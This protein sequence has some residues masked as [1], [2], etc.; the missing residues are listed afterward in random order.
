MGDE[1]ALHAN[2]VAQITENPLRPS[3]PVSESPH[4]HLFKA[5][6]EQGEALFEPATF[7][8]TPYYRNAAQ[9]LGFNGAYFQAWRENEIAA[10]ARNFVHLLDNPE[11]FVGGIGHSLPGEPIRAREIRY[12]DCYC[13]IDGH[14]RLGI[15]SARGERTAAVQVLRPAMVTPIQSKLLDAMWT[16]ASHQLYQPVDV[17]EV[18]NPC[19]TVIRRC[20]DR[21]SMMRQFLAG[22]TDTGNLNSYVDVASGYG[23][24]VH[25]MRAL[26]YSSYGVE[27]D[28]I[29]QSIGHHVWDIPET[30]LIRSEAVRFLESA[31]A[32][33]E[34]YDIVSCLSL[35]HHFILGR[36][37]VTA[38]QFIG[39]L[40]TLTRHVLFLDTGQ[41]TESW[42]SESLAEWTPDYIRSW[43]MERTGFREVIPLG[44]DA[45]GRGEFEGNYGRT[46]FACLK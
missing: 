6:L 8:Q 24:F 28:P 34:Q 1:A 13:V 18:L 20:D 11:G 32:G 38:E 7:E 9:V 31:A 40:H 25:H 14:H 33:S 5:Y 21:L 43:I 10:V 29:A 37:C 16:G 45:D 44:A 46:L 36:G 27:I 15:A 39:L 35:L 41:A 4:A 17:P 26:G 30:N 12:S 22:L 42:F 3:T 2:V 19:W 23:Y